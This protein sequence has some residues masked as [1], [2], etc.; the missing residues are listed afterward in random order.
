M[1]P[2]NQA[3]FHACEWEN[4]SYSVSG[5]PS[6]ARLGAIG[7]FAGAGQHVQGSPV[8]RYGAR[9]FG[10]EKTKAGRCTQFLEYSSTQARVERVS[11]GGERVS[12]RSA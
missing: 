10:R 11:L 7:Q 9:A 4:A 12:W 8:G 3:E 2:K 5:V 6:L 1:F